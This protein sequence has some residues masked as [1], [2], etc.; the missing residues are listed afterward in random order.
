MKISEYSRDS[1]I[2]D[3]YS[4][5]FNQK[6][7]NV[8]DILGFS[9]NCLV[10]SVCTIIIPERTAKLNILMSIY[11]SLQTCCYIICL[12]YF[13]TENYFVTVMSPFAED[14]IVAIS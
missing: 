8:N 11:T 13:Q 10:I 5:I 1:K 3:Q 7:W 6:S 9:I 4:K 14:S 12:I 2:F